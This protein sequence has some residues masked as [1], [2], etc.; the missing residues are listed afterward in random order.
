M[1]FGNGHYLIDPFEGQISQHTYRLYELWQQRALLTSVAPDKWGYKERLL[2]DLFVLLPADVRGQCMLV[3]SF[4]R[5][6]QPEFKALHHSLMTRAK[7]T[8]ATPH[9]SKNLNLKKIKDLKAFLGDDLFKW[10]AATV[11]YPHPTWEIMLAVGK[12]IYPPLVNYENILTMSHVPWLQTGTIPR[13]LRTEWL[14][15]LKD[16]DRKMGSRIEKIARKNVISLLTTALEDLQTMSNKSLATCDL[17]KE[18]TL[19]R[20]AFDKDDIE[21]QQELQYLLESGKIDGKHK[22]LVSNKFTKKFKSLKFAL[23]SAICLVPWAIMSAALSTVD[24]SQV[25]LKPPFVQ[26]EVVSSDIKETEIFNSVV[27]KYNNAVNNYNKGEFKIAIEDFEAVFNAGGAALFKNKAHHGMGL[28]YY[29][30]GDKE[31][32]RES[33]KSLLGVGFYHD[34]VTPN[35][36]TLLGTSDPGHQPSNTIT[37]KEFVEIPAGEFLMGSDKGDTDEKP[38]HRV[39]SILLIQNE[40]L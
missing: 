31:R 24:I 1:V 28:S 32:A 21:A 15:A 13:K 2:N 33:N 18:L 37:I 22:V 36:S 8:A 16:M 6:G 4:Q 38:P 39:T 10:L 7:R 34:W 9:S 35:L 3:E 14:T 27:D 11:V 5:K 20:A 40:Q 19:Q 30:N 26:D 17:N 12:A 29:Y 25:Q 23:R